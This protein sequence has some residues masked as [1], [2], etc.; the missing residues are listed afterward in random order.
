[1]AFHFPLRFNFLK[2]NFKKLRILISELLKN[3]KF[4]NLTVFEILNFNF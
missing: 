1:M 4:E 2:F 3:S